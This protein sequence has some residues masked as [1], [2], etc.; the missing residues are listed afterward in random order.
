M[1]FYSE[2]QANSISGVMEIDDFGFGAPWD[3]QP[4]VSKRM[5][6]EIRQKKA[7]LRPPFFFSCDSKSI[8]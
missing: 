1:E 8:P 7:A 5:A 4:R 2:G 6:A 3:L